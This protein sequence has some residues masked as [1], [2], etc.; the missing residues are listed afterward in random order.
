MKMQ[1]ADPTNAESAVEDTDSGGAES[2][3][4]ENPVFKPPLNVGIFL[5]SLRPTAA[6]E[7]RFQGSIFDAL[8]KANRPDFKLF[9]LTYELPD[10]TQASSS[11][12]YVKLR[13]SSGRVARAAALWAQLAGRYARSLISLFGGSGGAIDQATARWMRREPDHFQQLRDLNIRIIWNLSQKVLESPIPFTMVM[14]DVNH[15]IHSMYPEFSYARYGFD[16][17]EANY[18]YLLARASYV[19]VGTEEG[20]RQLVDMYGVHAGKIHVTPFPTPRLPGADVAGSGDR[21]P[22]IFYPAR[23]WPHKNH[24]VIV[25]ALKIL[26]ERW[27]MRL[28]C[29]FSGADEGNLDYVLRVA[30][31]LG[32]RDQIEYVGT[33][34][35][36][37]VGELYRHAFALVYASAVG[38][39][40]LPPLEAMALSCPVL[41]ADVPGAREQYGDAALF[42]SPTDERA[43]AALLKTLKDDPDLRQSLIDRGRRRAADWTPEDYV[44]SVFD[45]LQE[46]ALTARAWERCDSQF[47]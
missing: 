5:A 21:P 34:S 6:A 39:D 40:N 24:V 10:E 25:A 4:A 19:L 32:V 46:F 8:A 30:E 16:G 29:V 14:W 18:P 41:T 33:V 22:Y 11:V 15:R 12:T 3:V 38:P 36:E 42:F 7:Q 17:C 43:L 13:A 26:R 9:V 45:V 28:R 1:R 47:T 27:G 37:Q 35:E 44:D 31:D 20:K 2:I 23:F